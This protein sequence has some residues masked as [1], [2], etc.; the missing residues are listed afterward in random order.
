LVRNHSDCYNDLPILKNGSF[1]GQKR[2]GGLY[3]GLSC[4]WTKPFNPSAEAFG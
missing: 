3:A 1:A 2:F 4:F